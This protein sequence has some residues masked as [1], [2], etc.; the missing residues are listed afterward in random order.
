[1][2]HPA[3]QAFDWGNGY[4]ADGASEGRLSEMAFGKNPHRT[5]WLEL[6]KYLSNGTITPHQ[7]RRC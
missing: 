7:H 3:A 2:P 1:M 6:R 4:S 5:E